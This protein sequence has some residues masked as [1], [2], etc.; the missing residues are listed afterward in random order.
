MPIYV[1]ACNRCGMEIEKVTTNARLVV[2]EAISNVCMTC[3]VST[4]HEKVISAP[5]VVGHG[6]GGNPAFSLRD[7]RPARDKSW[8]KRVL[9]GKN[10][11]GKPLT[12][13]VQESAKFWGG[14]KNSLDR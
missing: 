8:K 6:P 4:R 5:S 10:A 3:G 14:A 2:P 1:F 13:R 11:D 9:E 7:V 12:N